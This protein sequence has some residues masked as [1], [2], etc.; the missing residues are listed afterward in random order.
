MGR[1]ENWKL[2]VESAKLKSESHLRVAQHWE[3]I[4]NIINFT[5]ILFSTMTTI[6]ALIK[7]HNN[8]PYYVTAIVSGI[9]TLL[10]ALS[11]FLQPHQ[12]QQ[13]QLES[14]KEFNALMMRMI[15]CVDENEF[16]QL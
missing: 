2:F 10:S 16:E 9:T 1:K 13:A 4:D 12:R 7:D 5:L 3:R 14:S 8:L 6:L 11:G 15:R